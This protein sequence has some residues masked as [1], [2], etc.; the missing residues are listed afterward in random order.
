MQHLGTSH[1]VLNTAPQ[2]HEPEVSVCIDKSEA[3]LSAGWLNMLS[4]FHDYKKVWHHIKS[5]LTAW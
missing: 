2:P 1:C 5:D 3:V 4:P